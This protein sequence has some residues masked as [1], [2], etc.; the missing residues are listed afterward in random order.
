MNSLK[1]T[2]YLLILLFFIGLHSFGQT[3]DTIRIEGKDLFVYPFKV[4]T[5]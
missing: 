1:K 2:S 4:E 3:A 5:K